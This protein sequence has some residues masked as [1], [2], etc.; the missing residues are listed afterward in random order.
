M[1][2]IYALFDTNVFTPSSSASITV[3]S[4]SGDFCVTV[5]NAAA[6]H[7][8]STSVTFDFSSNGDTVATV[9]FV[10]D[11]WKKDYSVL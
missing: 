8:S 5:I 1:Y 3:E 6:E 10:L 9:D 2:V 7:W 11:L 4:S